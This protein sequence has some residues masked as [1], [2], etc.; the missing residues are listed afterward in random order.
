[1][2][3]SEYI[4]I[5]IMTID[6][7]MAKPI[8]AMDQ[9]TTPFAP[10]NVT[11]QRVPIIRIFGA[12]PWGQKACVHVHQVYPYFY[13]P[14]EGS[15]DSDEL[16]LFI[17]KLG[18]NINR[19]VALSLGCKSEDL[20][21]QQHVAAI[22]PVKGVPF[23]GFHA[24]YRYFL[25]IYIV[26]P[27]LMKRIAG[28]LASGAVL[29]QK[30]QPYESHIAYLPQFFI[31]HNLL[32]MGYMR[33]RRVQFRLPITDIERPNAP[34][35]SIYY[36]ED[37]I[38]TSMK[39]P[40]DFTS[41]PD[42]HSWCELEF[43]IL[44]I[45]ILNRTSIA[46]RPTMPLVQANR[47]LAA[48]D[49]TKLVPSLA[50]IWESEANRRLKLGLN[51]TP[52]IPKQTED[53]LE[54]EPWYNENL[55]REILDRSVQESTP[56]THEASPEG[57][58]LN[59]Q[60]LFA[61]LSDDGI[62]TAFESVTALYH[63]GV[64]TKRRLP[65]L[66]RINSGEDAHL[67]EAADWMTNMT[68][69]KPE[70]VASSKLE[71]DEAAILQTQK[72]EEEEAK[73][74]CSGEERE[75]HA[76]SESEGDAN[77]ENEED[78]YDEPESSE[79]WWQ[80]MQGNQPVHDSDVQDSLPVLMQ[81]DGHDDI[82]DS[83]DEDRRSRKRKRSISNVRSLYQTPQPAK[84]EVL[85]GS[86][87]S[88]LK[89]SS[90]STAGRVS[91]ADTSSPTSNRLH[92]DLNHK[93]K[94]SIPQFPPPV[95]VGTTYF[96]SSIMEMWSPDSVKE[97]ESWNIDD[98]AP[99]VSSPTDVREEQQALSTEAFDFGAESPPSTSTAS[100]PPHQVA[101]D[102]TVPELVAEP[103]NFLS[104]VESLQ[105][106]LSRGSPSV[107]SQT[108]R[109]RGYFELGD[110]A[111]M[112]AFNGTETLNEAVDA[113][114]R[115]NFATNAALTNGSEK[116]LERERNIWTMASQ[117][118][119]VERVR[120]WLASNSTAGTLSQNER[121]RIR[122]EKMAPQ[123]EGPTP[124]NKFGFKY[125]QLRSGAL[126]HELEHLVLFSLEFHAQT[127]KN[128]LP[129]PLHDAVNT[130]F[131]CIQSDEEERFPRNGQKEG[132]HVGI[133]TIL[134]CFPVKTT[135]ISGF[136]VDTVESELALFTRLVEIIREVD[137]DI[138]V[139]Y[140]I[141]SASWGYLID[142][143]HSALNMDLASCIS[144]V[145]FGAKTKVN[146]EENEYGFQHDSALYASGRIFLNVWRLLKSELTLTSY[147]LE[148]TV[149]HALHERIP[150]Y[151]HETLSRWYG[152]SAVTRWRV[153]RYY[154]QRVQLNI[155]L[156]DDTSKISR[157]SEFARVYGIDFFSV[158]SRGSQFQVESIMARITKPENFIMI[159]PTPTMIREMRAIDC[160][161]LILEPESRF[162]NNPMAVLDFQ[163]L[164][165]SVMIAYN[166][167]FSTCLG[168]VNSIGKPHK[169]GCMGELSVP[170]EVVAALKDHITVSPNGLAFVKPSIRRGVLGRMLTEILDTRFMIKEAMKTYKND[171]ALLRIL[172]AQQLSLKLIANVTYGYAGAS[173]SGRMPCS[174]IADAI[175]QTGRASL[176]MA[177]RVVQQN[178]Q[179][180]G[181][182]VYGDTDSMFVN[183]P[184]MSKEKAFQV[185][186]TIAK[187]VS[188]K[189]AHPMKLKFEKIYLPSVL[190]TKKRY[191]GFM[192]ESVDDE[193]P[194][195]DAKG[196]E[197]VRRDGCPA[198]A[199]MME[200]SLKILFRT[201]SMADLKAY[202]YRQWSKL[203]M[204]E[205]SY[206]DFIIATAVKMGHY[207]GNGPPGAQLSKARMQKDSRAEPQY[208][209]RVP[210]LVTQSGI[211]KTI[212]SSSYHPLDVLKDPS[213]KLNST[214]YIKQKIIPALERVFKLVSIDLRTWFDEMPRVYK[215][216]SAH[217]EQTVTL[218]TRRLQT[219]DR[220][221][222]ARVCIVC[223]GPSNEQDFCASC[224]THPKETLAIVSHKL[225]E[226]E[227]KHSVLQE[228]CR[229][230]EGMDPAA[231][232]P[233]VAC[234][235]V[236]CPVLFARVQAAN[237]M[238]T[239]GPRL[240]RALAACLEI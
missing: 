55:L 111:P 88:S 31:D 6:F 62:L 58:D 155:R 189:T 90:R 222:A 102:R 206:N 123:I 144:R 148:N 93:S 234:E 230:C 160:L 141:H 74:S 225:R 154:L 72:A 162:Y 103:T 165:P 215:A 235:S 70:I 35:S 166:Y 108:A 190:L 56:K 9:T 101:N 156:L 180:G 224:Q 200:Q 20:S 7:T 229:S 227:R 151:S 129:D 114:R 196:I 131:Y 145:L 28:L 110:L 121:E 150:K 130:I 106:Q 89:K 177:M 47:N 104:S 86:R 205:V 134:D 214:Y 187:E 188:R 2:A 113:K 43:D 91:F 232:D 125:S 4:A 78:A 5:R 13:I 38:P 57:R 126:S 228:L 45:D 118:P 73:V 128:Y 122:R 193:Q 39:W 84:S 34:P 174:D 185:G 124:K 83:S 27:N 65:A 183:L 64:G 87:K 68:Q 202:L 240:N 66:S 79:I 159:S 226:L 133:I 97:L 49:E 26:Q 211:Q 50:S 208:G 109:F 24:S 98:E 75:E 203:M 85:E 210:Y 80:E 16:Q 99:L 178:P 52:A 223:D 25:K 41:G 21:R 146:E 198:V 216:F 161:P 204:D 207:R 17:C 120:V 14:Y 184:D 119:S 219:I 213:L 169:F 107:I 231:A 173:F 112:T 18:I 238:R 46:E 3:A 92:S 142:R 191:V 96:T 67:V 218:A 221:Y 48:N 168:R 33:I 179:W 152:Q 44:A 239:T 36:R 135:G 76:E 140:E 71:V 132:Y 220:F 100:F 217:E 137:P 116:S 51:P 23:Y 53:R 186:H 8:P 10:L 1:M 115:V 171:K 143:A 54:P 139:G 192:Y 176:E 201:R 105:S 212:A 12:T 127:R 147:T 153:L 19:A 11:L 164:Y 22:I 181:R 194:A 63:G 94:W 167:C 158:I 95:P 182:V 40:I 32:G 61:T 199:K 170:M 30:F 59:H 117:P 195:F 42:R 172:D 29:R 77:Y 81:L 149:F 236:D 15:L 163:S 60:S 37:N 82:E 138:L 197:T 136:V 175:V 157:T 209:E 233:I 237:R 69:A